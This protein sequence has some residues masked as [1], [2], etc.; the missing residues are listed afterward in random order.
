MAISK[1]GFDAVVANN[2]TGGFLMMR[3]VF[4]QC[5]Q[6]HGG[7]DRQHDGRLPQRHARHGPLRAPPAP[8]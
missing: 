6:K 3:E 7:C 2:L 8:A 1:R 5:M 4:N